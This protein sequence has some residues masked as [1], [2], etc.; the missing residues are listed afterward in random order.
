MASFLASCFFFQKNPLDFYNDENF[1]S[2]FELFKYLFPE[3]GTG[4][5]LKNYNVI[6]IDS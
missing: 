1:S 4:N 6:A 2:F 3:F 5:D